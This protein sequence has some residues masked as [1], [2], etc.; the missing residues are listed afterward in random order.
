VFRVPVL[1]GAVDDAKGEGESA[2]NTLLDVVW[3]EKKRKEVQMDHWS[4]RYPTNTRDVARVLA[5][6]SG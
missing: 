2:V 1:Y 6:V 3:N 5:D 4:L